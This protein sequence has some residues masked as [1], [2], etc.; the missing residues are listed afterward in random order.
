MST[1]PCDWKDYLAGDKSDL[2]F[3]AAFKYGGGSEDGQ[4]RAAIGRFNGYVKRR[5]ITLQRL[6]DEIML[7]DVCQTGEWPGTQSSGCRF[8]IKFTATSGIDS[9]KFIDDIESAVENMRFLRV[10]ETGVW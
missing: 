5:E 9:D 1:N 10:A 6:S 2:I 7:Q 8:G 3:V 4:F